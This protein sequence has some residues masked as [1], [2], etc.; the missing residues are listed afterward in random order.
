MTDVSNT[1]SDVCAYS[2]AYG[3]RTAGGGADQCGQDS[4]VD[5]DPGVGGQR[6]CG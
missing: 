4:G 6:V 3:E 1:G 5:S 2:S